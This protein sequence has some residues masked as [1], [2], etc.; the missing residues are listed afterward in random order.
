M[1]SAANA[2]AAWSSP[3]LL[4]MPPMPPFAGG[5]SSCSA[6]GGGRTH[7]PVRDDDDD[8]F[9]DEFDGERDV[10]TAPRRQRPPPPPSLPPASPAREPSAVNAVPEHEYTSS[11]PPP[12]VP[13]W[14][15]RLRSESVEH[16]EAI[17]AW[18][19]GDDSRA[20]CETVRALLSAGESGLARCA[21]M[22][23]DPSLRSG[24]RRLV[25]CT[26]ANDALVQR[27]VLLPRVRQ[28]ILDCAAPKMWRATS[29]SG[30][31]LSLQG[32]GAASHR[33][34][35]PSQLDV[36]LLAVAQLGADA[37]SL[38]DALAALLAREST[39]RAR[40]VPTLLAW[41]VHCVG[42]AGDRHLRRVASQ[43]GGARVASRAAAVKALA[44]PRPGAAAAAS[45]PAAR[46]AVQ[47]TCGAESEPSGG[48]SGG[49]ATD[50]WADHA[51]ADLIEEAALGGL[52]D[53]E[54]LIARLPRVSVRV[55]ERDFSAWVQE[56]T[57]G[58]AAQHA[59]AAGG[60]EESVAAADAFGAQLV[61]T[62]ASCQLLQRLCNAPLAMSE[63]RAA[64]RGSP[65]KRDEG[66][67]G[68]EQS[69]VRTAAAIACGRMLTYMERLPSSMR[70]SEGGVRDHR[71]LL[72]GAL[73][74]LLE[75]GGRAL[76][77]ASAEALGAITPN[78]AVRAMLLGT[79]TMMSASGAGS[80]VAGSPGSSGSSGSGSGSSV[81]A[82]LPLQLAAGAPQ[83]APPTLTAE[84]DEVA[85]CGDAVLPLAAL[86]HD[87]F[88]RVRAS[89]ARTL[90]QWGPLSQ[91]ALDQLMHIVRESPQC[92]DA[93]AEAVAATGARGV[94]LLLE[95][96]T[97][98]ETNAAVAVAAAHG[99]AHIALE[100]PAAT[101]SSGGASTVTTAW[102]ARNG[103]R[104]VLLDSA[105]RVGS[106]WVALVH[107]VARVLNAISLGAGGRGGG[108]GDDREPL[109]EPR[110]LVRAA[111]LR[112]LGLM[113]A[114]THSSLLDE[115]C[116]GGSDFRTEVPPM[117]HSGNGNGNG[118]SERL[119]RV[120]H[121]P[122]IKSKQ[123]V[124]WYRDHRARWMQSEEKARRARRANSYASTPPTS[125]RHRELTP[126]IRTESYLPLV[127]SRLYDSSRTVRVTAA[128]LLAGIG[129][130]G[131]LAL[132]QVLH[133]TT[134]T[135]AMAPTAAHM[136]VAGRRAAVVGLGCVGVRSVSTLLL[137]LGDGEPVIRYEAEH[138]VSSLGAA[139]V[140][141]E[142]ARRSGAQRDV[143]A[144]S[145]RQAVAR[146]EGGGEGEGESSLYRSTKGAAGTPVRTPYRTSG[147]EGQ[148][149]RVLDVLHALRAGLARA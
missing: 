82:V 79:S 110:S 92:R 60:E 147:R 26:L 117:M 3:T 126:F 7:S 71:A 111:S 53:A 1:R 12:S 36:G 24:V 137:A 40:E 63:S 83:P 98:A 66:R 64:D 96:L 146:L 124:S 142:L 148:S 118:G 140:L 16:A 95:L 28:H 20:C 104:S 119:G 77:I 10:A 122:E 125:R 86:L 103:R 29:R 99:L 109:V 138:A 141:A 5:S 85:L 59:A 50:A 35:T 73:A 38:A 108:S 102:L 143:A 41:A 94:R 42:P 121:S 69:I 4:P 136:V 11:S 145:V 100:L 56:C 22:L 13:R 52:R 27:L 75:H 91:P 58:M 23:D 9:D 149:R 133:C 139:A 25:L 68:V 120:L 54:R 70:S 134:T 106:E 72:V 80:S 44:L 15:R 61:S 14:E 43:R 115:G 65:Q 33:S 48:E 67:D 62:R 114:R 101:S 116:G 89:A 123:M 18:R 34:T 21:A 57:R 135:A 107:D 2:A 129:P 105:E 84:Q 45:R 128:T 132:N 8:K 49:T 113:W 6:W 130:R 88:W 112:A 46:L 55:D 87:P 19:E 144:Q 37:E 76:R 32:V 17:A 31:V 131:E 78:G 127:T 81:V 39:S 97:G 51:V 30:L 47:V 90:A 93:A 74:R